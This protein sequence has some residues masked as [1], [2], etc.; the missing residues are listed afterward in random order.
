MSDVSVTR[1]VADHVRSLR[2]QRRWSARQLAEEC[3]RAGAT[4]LTRGTIA[5][6][7]S[8]GRKYVTADE[9]AVLAR[10]LGVSPS[11]LLTS[12]AAPVASADSRFWA[13]D[14][15]EALGPLARELAADDTAQGLQQREVVILEG[16][17]I[18]PPPAVVGPRFDGQRMYVMQGVGGTLRFDDQTLSKHVLFLGGIGTGKS[19][20]MM[21]FVRS[22]RDNVGQDDV[23]VIFDPKGDFRREFYQDGDAVVSST[24]GQ[25]SGGVV[26][27][28][29]LELPGDDASARGDQIHEI[30]A[31]VFSLGQAG[32]NF[33][34]ANAACD[35]FAAVVEIMM[36]EG[37]QHS[38]ADLRDR[39]ERDSGEL[40][41]ELEAHPD[42][43][44]TA[45]YLR[46]ELTRQS[47]LAFLQQTLNSSF[48]GAFRLPD[49][50]LSVRDFVRA[51]AGRALF[52]EYDIA[53]GGRQLPIYRVLM[54]MAIKEALSMGRRPGASGNVYFVMDEFA[55]LPQLSHITDGIN[56]GRSLGLKFLVA[57]QNVSQVLRAHG[58]DVGNRMLSGFGTVLAFRLMDE[59]SRDL[60]RQRFGGNRKQ[61]TTYAAV[62]SERVQQIVVAGNVIEDWHVSDLGRGECV[63]SLPDG[64][65]F[66]FAF[67]KY[68]ASGQ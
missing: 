2:A 5:K 68:P 30:A 12:G 66:F 49:G 62:R 59:S 57:T 64:P 16:M 27:N 21:Q 1:Q 10:V 42:L 18:G 43:A 29:F 45:R 44:G 14:E 31:T 11:A 67:G 22:L 47:V 6:I 35:I 34:F 53:V 25:D 32:Q 56:F 20:A 38:N 28:L 36:R 52:I 41:D 26:W 54:D 51:R 4:S 61:I 46:G 24:P 9:L 48:S 13:G 37:G 55:L 33:F 7:E 58:A 8:G 19:N 50:T 17:T 60:V 3:A 23:F 40:L 39:L 65:P 15:S 63:V